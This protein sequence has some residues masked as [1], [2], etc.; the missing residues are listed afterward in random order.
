MSKPTQYICPNCEHEFEHV[1]DSSMRVVD[2]AVRM[3]N[4]DGSPA[5]ECPEC[6]TLGKKDPN[7]KV[8]IC[9]FTSRKGGVVGSDWTNTHS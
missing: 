2:G 3:F 8:T 9:G 1:G 6:G 4:P 5:D 7:R